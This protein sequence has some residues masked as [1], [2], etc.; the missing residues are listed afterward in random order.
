[1]K[2]IVHDTFGSPDVLHQTDV[3]KP[4]VGDHDVLVH[5]HAAA[6]N[7]A[8][9]HFMR[10]EPYI[11]RGALGMRRPKHRVAG[12][13]VAGEVEAVGGAVTNLHPGDA[14]F[15]SCEGAFA[16]YASGDAND[17]A[18]KPTDLTFEQAAAVPMAAVTALQLL[19]DIAR[20]Q[21]GQKVLINGASGGVGTFAVQLAKWLGADV[22]GVCSTHNVD[23]VRSIGADHVIDYTQQDF[24]QTEQQY[25]V[26]L[27]NVGNHSLS[28]CRRALVHGGTLIPNSG[29]GGHVIGPVGRL[30]AARIMSPFVPQK[31]GFKVAEIHS[32]DLRLLSELL[33]AGTIRPVIDRTYPLSQVPDAMRYLE[34]G[35]VH[36]KVVITV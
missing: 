34:E 24:T 22:T 29:S 2:A 31:M 25:D 13:D 5:V 12:T 15:G 17:F 36:G 35:H 21:P 9:W 11:A 14:V 10:G 7:P 8:D 27:D 3:D 4:V 19:R 30:T 1:M 18:P 16:E 6:I 23:M 26:I 20:V 32:D 28:E 33:E